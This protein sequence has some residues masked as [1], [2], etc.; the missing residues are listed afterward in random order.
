MPR[1]ALLRLALCIGPAATALAADAPRPNILL[2]YTDDQPYKT[3]GCYPEAPRWV[4]TPRI[5]RLAETGI[6]FHRSYLGPWC[7]PSRA[8]M[9]TGRLSFGIESMRM[10]GKYPGSDYDPAQ[11]R[12]WP[13]IFRQQG[14]QTAQIGKWH[15]GTDTG[16]GR[17]WDHQ[18]VWN[19]PAHPENAGAYYGEQILTFDGTERRVA[20]YST[21]NYTDWAVDY[22]RGDHRD[23]KKPWFLWVC[24][25]AIHGPTTPAPRHLGAYANEEV[26]LPTD[27]FGPRPGKPDYLNA[28]QAWEP[29]PD[30]KSAVKRRPGGGKEGKPPVDYRNWVRQINECVLAIDEGVGRIMAA[31]EESGQL[32]NTLV[33][34]TADQG[35]AQGEHGFSH[36]LAPY[37]ANLASP[38]IVSQPG[39]IP[40]GKVC[41]HA[42]S[43]TDLVA[44]FCRIAGVEIPW[45]LHGRD[46]TPLFRDP[47]TADWNTPMLM[48][49][50]GRRYGSDTRVIPTDKLL[51]E[52]GG[53]PWWVM[54]RD[55]RHKYIRTLKAGAPEEIYDLDQD[56]EELTNLALRPEN[57][58]MLESLRAKAIA[59]LR[60]TDAGFV[61]AMPA[62]RQTAPP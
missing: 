10:V 26:A 34:F 59:E 31:L 2:I 39:T 35:F 45:K 41:R 4:R 44:T 21:D 56:P 32:N 20:G 30:G 7:M 46:I 29:G 8:I 48:T 42:V 61:D 55:G 33:V 38:L 6:R 9:L 60:R 19:R 22:I 18:I 37:D 49:H 24:Y 15:T 14:Y 11:C 62:T 57:G 17:D 3:V 23:G 16:W 36:K 47:E 27:I 25:G 5:D 1:T 43:S 58:T 51:T 40:R 12:F 53:I 13:A 28:T 52:T 50:H 54:I